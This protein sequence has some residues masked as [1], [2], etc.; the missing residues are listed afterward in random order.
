[1]RSDDFVPPPSWFQCSSAPKDGRYQNCGRTCVILSLDARFQCSS[2]PKDGRYSWDTSRDQHQP[3]SML[4]RPEGRTLRLLSVRTMIFAPAKVSMLVRPEGRTLHSG[5]R[6]F[7]D[8]K[9]WVSMLVRPEGR[10]LPATPHKPPHKRPRG[11]NARPPRRTDA[12]R[13]H[14]HRH[15]LCKR[16]NA[17]PPRRTDATCAIGVGTAISLF[18]VS[19]LVR[20][21]GRTL[22]TLS[23]FDQRRRADCF[24]AR[25]PRRTD[26]T[27]PTY[28]DLPLGVCFNARPPRRTD[29]TISAR[30]LLQ[31]LWFQCSSAPKD[32]RYS[33]VLLRSRAVDQSFQCSSAPKDGR[34]WLGREGSC[35]ALG[36]SMLVRPEG[37][38]LR[39]T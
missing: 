23:V 5:S 24:N 27:W 25:P 17:R 22:P 19:M 11:F 9:P 15:P 3:V 12:T 10:T 13:Y 7:K 38:T 6:R 21:E 32:G 2:A 33:V 26:A 34:Y 28:D 35:N 39:G 29:A 31:K 14:L 1:M 30:Q 20:P 4:V 36:V 16:F 37:R 18:F 8:R